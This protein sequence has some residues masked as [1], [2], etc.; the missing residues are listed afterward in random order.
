M[1]EEI[2]NYAA[3][4]CAAKSLPFTPAVMALDCV[5]ATLSTIVTDSISQKS[6]SDLFA[7]GHKAEATVIKKIEVRVHP[8]RR[9]WQEEGVR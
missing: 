3:Q 8:C 1:V 5:C 6:I 9:G 2:K 7:H 4:Y